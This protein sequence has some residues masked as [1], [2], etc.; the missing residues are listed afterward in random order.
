MTHSVIAASPQHATVEVRS[1]SPVQCLDE[2]PRILYCVLT[3]PCAG[4]KIKMDRLWKAARKYDRKL[5]SINGNSTSSQGGWS[6][7]SYDCSQVL[8]AKIVF[9]PGTRLKS[10]SRTCSILSVKETSMKFQHC[11]FRFAHTR[12]SHNLDCDLWGLL[13]MI[14]DH[15]TLRPRIH[16]SW[17]W[18]TIFFKASIFHS[19]LSS[20]Q[21]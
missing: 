3:V 13:Y 7:Q 19:E 18:F 8:K 12:F 11:E 9:Q 10:L 20:Y 1:K 15:E 2:V 5:V 16:S 17:T 6:V 14:S 21:N 4:N